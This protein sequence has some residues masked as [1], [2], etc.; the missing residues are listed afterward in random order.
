MEASALS[1]PVGLSRGPGPGRWLRLRSD[2]QLVSLF[3]SGSE[4]AFRVIHDRYRQ[5]L[6][7]YARQMLGGSGSD[8]EDVMQDV[9]LRAYR[10]LRVDERPVSLRAWLY[11]VAHN[12]CVDQLRRPT[13]PPA[14]VFELSRAP[15][16]DPLAIA[17]RREDLRRLVAD[18]RRLPAQQRSALLMREMDGMSYADLAVALE[19]SVPAVKSLLVR[20]RIGLVE[21]IEARDADCA[22]IRHDLA[23]SYDRGV[24]A[25]GRARRHLRDCDACTHYRTQLRGVRHGFAALSPS[26]APLAALA[27]LLG[28]GG[29]G[30]SAAAG[31]AAAGSGAGALGGGAVAAVS[32]S[33]VAVVVC[34]AVAVTGGAAEVRQTL[35]RASRPAVER[36]VA[37]V[38]ASVVASAAAR[39][40]AT[41]TLAP[42]GPATALRDAGPREAPARPAAPSRPQPD[43]GPGGVLA[44]PDPAAGDAMPAVADTVA[45]TVDALGGPIAGT[46]DEASASPAGDAPADADQP[47]GDAPSAQPS[48][49]ESSS[50]SGTGSSPDTSAPASGSSSGS[51]SSTGTAPAPGHRTG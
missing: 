43:N 3:R 23:A 1:A 16:Q 13:P 22:D 25:S 33:K 29:A 49:A 51:D 27:K 12:R 2:E 36:A 17:E 11:R 35:E 18:V 44:P 31:G 15:L 26:P 42:G 47:S 48:P 19:T 40:T 34:C 10:A 37:A 28:I 46:V 5:R 24:R 9:F 45:P 20:A 39:L 50:P 41:S 4:E 14:D 21:A 7:A 8:A 32:A 6:Y 30:S 38:P